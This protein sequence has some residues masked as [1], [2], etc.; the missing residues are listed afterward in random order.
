MKNAVALREGAP[1][2]GDKADPNTLFSHM[3]GLSRS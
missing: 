2:L 3:E 1:I